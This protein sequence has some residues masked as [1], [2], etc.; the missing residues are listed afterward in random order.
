MR[1]YLVLALIPMFFGAMAC[2]KSEEPAPESSGSC[3]FCRGQ[4]GGGGEAAPSGGAME[5]SPAAGLSAAP[6]RLS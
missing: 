4:P 6:V 2:Q 3:C 5:A 1:K